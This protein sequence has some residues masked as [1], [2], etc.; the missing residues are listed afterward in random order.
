MKLYGL[1]LVKDEADVIGQSLRH[2]M[3]FCD[4]IAVLDNGSSDDSFAVV[5]EIASENPGRVLAWGVDPQPYHRGLR[6]LM[7][8]ELSAE[9]GEEDWFLQLDADEFLMED[10]RPHLAA[11]GR[12][13]FDQV[14]TWQAQFQFTDVDLARWEEGLDDRDLPIEQRRRHFVVDWRE[15]RFFRNGPG[16]EWRG[17]TTNLP[18][19][20]TRAPHARL[21]N[22]HYQ[23]R[24]P[25]QIQRRLEIRAAVRSEH[26][27]THVT[28]TEWRHHVVAAS[29]LRIWHPGEALRPRPWRYYLRRARSMSGMG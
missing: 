20:V 12:R 10:P 7:Y 9:L 2:A 26:A 17:T 14:A 18:E 29:G 28:D 16:R 24:D 6:S 21:V 19:W 3:E 4:R 15:G 8:G 27:F 5:E 25:D 13:G 23:F 22:R 1:A 11:V